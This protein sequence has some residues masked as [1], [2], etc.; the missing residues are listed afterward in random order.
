MRKSVI[1]SAAVLA[2][3]HVTGS[4]AQDAEAVW[5]HVAQTATAT[6]EADARTLHFIRKDDGSIVIGIVG[7]ETTT[8][9]IVT[10]SRLVI[11]ADTCKKGS[12][13][14]FIADINGENRHAN[15]FSANG[16]TVASEMGRQLCRLYS[17]KVRPV[18]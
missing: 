18:E 12:G 2:I 1:A 16:K 9:G 4:F 15:A 11:A 17:R 14:L 13:P 5:L 6:Y 10:V 7:R 8:S 3:F